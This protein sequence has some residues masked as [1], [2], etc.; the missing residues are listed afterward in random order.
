MKEKWD[1]AE[2]ELYSVSLL[3]SKG[4]PGRWERSPSATMEEVDSEEATSGALIALTEV[5]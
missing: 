1:K 5:W 4:Q 3:A 2:A